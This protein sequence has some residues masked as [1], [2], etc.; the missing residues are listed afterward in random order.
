LH[1]QTGGANIDVVIAAV[2]V[3][4]EDAD[5]LDLSPPGPESAQSN[6]PQGKHL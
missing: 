4:Y 1:R 2:V 3:V 5:V 6:W